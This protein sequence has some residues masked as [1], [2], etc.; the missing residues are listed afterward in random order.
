MT[1]QITVEE[2]LRLLYD[3]QFI[4]SK[5]DSIK[6]LR[7]ELPLE[8]KNLED[9]IACFQTKIKKLQTSIEEIDLDISQKKQDIEAH[10]SMVKKYEQ[11]QK[12]IRNNREYEALNKEIEFEFLE[13]ELAEK[14]IKNNISNK[15]KAKEDIDLITDLLAKKNEEFE[16]SKKE[17]KTILKETEKEEKIL[18]DKSEEFK[19]LLDDRLLT[20]Y[21][22]IR[23]KVRNGLAVV[24]IERDAIEGSF[25]TIP[26]QR[27][28][29]LAARKKMIIDEH[30][31]RILVDPELA[32]EETDKMNE[33]L[34]S[35]Q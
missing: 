14:K 11:Q 20:S 28:I 8:V 16:I 33:I 22:R 4:D 7:G 30:S 10:R 6:S 26:P 31:G 12:G 5:I 32:R 19:K 17:L 34:S 3:L 2:K 9:D 1:K 29:E 23:S 18:N 15:E 13:I 35:L 24:S 21:E 25:F 27:K